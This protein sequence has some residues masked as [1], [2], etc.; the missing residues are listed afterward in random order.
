LGRLRKIFNSCEL[1]LV[2]A[3]A[4]FEKVSLGQ[5]LVD[6]H[7]QGSVMQSS[8]K[9]SPIPTPVAF[10]GVTNQPKTAM[11]VATRE[12]PDQKTTVSW[13]QKNL[14]SGP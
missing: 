13:C 10:D 7:L 6:Q 9:A 2:R 8:S 3:A 12:W 4:L 11:A 5:Y 14:A 1:F